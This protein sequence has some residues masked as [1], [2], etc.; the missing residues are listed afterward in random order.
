MYRALLSRYASTDEPIDSLDRCEFSADQGCGF[1]GDPIR[2][3]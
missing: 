3:P 1:R 2:D